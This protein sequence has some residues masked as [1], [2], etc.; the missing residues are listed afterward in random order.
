MKARPRGPLQSAS[1]PELLAKIERAD[2]AAFDAFYEEYFSRVYSYFRRR[3]GTVPEVEEATDCALT[4]IFEAISLGQ[5]QLPLE[6]WI[7]STVRA[8]EARRLKP[9]GLAKV[10]PKIVFVWSRLDTSTR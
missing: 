10:G 8:V 7:L 9:P 3:F 4:A 1:K 6:S 5:P 2:Q